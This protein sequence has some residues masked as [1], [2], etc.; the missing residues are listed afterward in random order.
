M[1]F[2]QSLFLLLKKFKLK[3]LNFSTLDKCL[4]VAIFFM[5]LTTLVT[6]LISPPNNWDSMTYHM[7][8]VE[9]WIQNKAIFFLKL[10]ILDKM[11]LLHSVNF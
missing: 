5:L 6:A 10:I 1:L 9:Y 2:L 3:R 4:L 8:R 7:S 11:F